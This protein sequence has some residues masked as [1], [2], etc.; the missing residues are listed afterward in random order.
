MKG[1]AANYWQSHTWRAGPGTCPWCPPPTACALC[2]EGGSI[3]CPEFDWR[4]LGRAASED[5]TLIYWLFWIV[6]PWKVKVTQSC[7]TL[8]PLNCTVHGI[9]QARILGVGSLS[10]FQGIF[11]TQGLN[12]GL[13]Q[14][15]QILYQLGHKVSS[16]PH[17]CRERLCLPHVP[18]VCL[19]AWKQILQK[20]LSCHR[21]PHQEFHH[22]EEIDPYHGKGD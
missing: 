9:L 3:C 8:W 19:S 12:P 7:L 5:A 17:K 21:A 13:L 1:R 2:V 11:T 20:E 16:E 22:P 14:C 6:G 4:S 15:P 10:L 18:V